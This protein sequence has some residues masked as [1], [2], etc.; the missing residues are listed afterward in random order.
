MS[1]VFDVTMGLASS[2]PPLPIA[3]GPTPFG[4]GAASGL[5]S[6]AAAFTPPTFSV[7]TPEAPSV[8]APSVASAPAP[9]L[10]A[11]PAPAAGARPTLS[12]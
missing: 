7:T 8:P 6:P 11:A 5:V 10:A 1:E 12:L 2:Y 3:T 9:A 4:S